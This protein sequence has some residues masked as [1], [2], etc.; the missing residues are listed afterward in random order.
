MVEVTMRH[1]N[2]RRTRAR[3]ETLFCGFG[4]HAGCAHHAGINKNP[5][6]GTGHAIEHDVGNREALPG[7]VGRDFVC[8]V[9]ACIVGLLVVC[10]AAFLER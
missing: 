3:A 5:L 7:K 8:A 6:S 1:D 2:G 9:V 10:D 4:N